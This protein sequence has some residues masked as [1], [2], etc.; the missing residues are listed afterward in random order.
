MHT[1]ITNTGLKWNDKFLTQ[2]KGQERHKYITEN[3]S[4][5]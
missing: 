4:H 5:K 2:L 1:S 3:I